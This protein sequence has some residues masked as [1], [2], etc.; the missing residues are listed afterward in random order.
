MQ[1]ASG[2]DDDDSST[3]PAVLITLKKVQGLIIY[4]MLTV[5][6]RDLRVSTSLRVGTVLLRRLCDVT[7]Q[8]NRATMESIDLGKE[9]RR[10]DS[11]TFLDT[12]AIAMHILENVPRC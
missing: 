4:P 12:R 1:L 5:G 9:S 3:V 6:Y 8:G 2:R 10:M 7:E 11:R